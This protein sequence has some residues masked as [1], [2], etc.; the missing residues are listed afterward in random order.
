MLTRECAGER[1]QLA[2][3]R[4]WRE[5]A[6]G[7]S[8]CW[9]EHMLARARAGDRARTQENAHARE[10]PA[11]AAVR[12]SG[13]YALEQ[14]VWH[15][16]LQRKLVEKEAPAPE[17]RGVD[18]ARWQRYLGRC[19]SQ[20]HH[21]RSVP[22]VLSQLLTDTTEALRG[23]P[24]EHRFHVFTKMRKEKRLRNTLFHACVIRCPQGCILHGG[25]PV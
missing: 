3:E 22:H 12:V 9:R 23:C 17:K 21:E 11:E 15:R 1:A 14:K 4:R 18:G 13:S 24:T 20:A 6:A 19:T 10:D 16:H 7:E 25:R 8:A 2:R 5:S